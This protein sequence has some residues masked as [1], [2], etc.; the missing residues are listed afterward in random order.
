MSRYYIA[1]HGI[2][3]QKWGIRRYRNR[4]GSLTAEEKQRRK[5]LDKFVRRGKRKVAKTVVK[6]VSNTIVMA[7]AAG[8]ATT[9]ITG[10]PYSAIPV[11]AVVVGV[12]WYKHTHI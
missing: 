12:R 3:G 8:I 6:Q 5:K 9:A 11:A 1:H 2:K 4:D 10:I 7:G